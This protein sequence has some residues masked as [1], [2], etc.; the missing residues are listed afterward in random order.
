MGLGDAVI[1]VP[2]IGSEER[3][4]FQNK[5]EKKQW[6]AVP[7]AAL[8]RIERPVGFVVAR[9]GGR[10]AAH[11]SLGTVHSTIRGDRG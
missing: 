6:V 9:K 2:G 11:C 5:K 1:S 3:V 4:L 10:C 7:A 8:A